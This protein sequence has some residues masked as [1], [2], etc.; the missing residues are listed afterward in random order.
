MYYK[1]TATDFSGNE[2]DPA[3]ATI[4]TAAPETPKLA[5]FTLHQNVPNPFNP[6]TTI[7]YELANAGGRVR[8]QIFDVSGRLVKTL[9]DEVQGAGENSVRWEGRDDSGRRVATGAYFYRLTSPGF[10]QTRKMVM[11]K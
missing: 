5:N 8:L 7:R 9:V 4:V 6:S 1:V 10:T 11:L 3:E 2:S